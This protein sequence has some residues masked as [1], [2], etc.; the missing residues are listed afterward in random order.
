MKDYYHMNKA[1]VSI[2]ARV[3]PALKANISNFKDE[4]LTAT[5]DSQAIEFLLD[6]GISAINAIMEKG[7]TQ[8]EAL[9]IL[10]SNAMNCKRK[11]EDRR[12]VLEE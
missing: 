7:Y 12:I 3:T 8:N 2:Q 1:K 4:H 9:T 6:A 5:S 11:G 10:G